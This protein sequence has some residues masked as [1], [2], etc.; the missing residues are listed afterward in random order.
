MGHCAHPKKGGLQ[1]IHQMK[2][3]IVQRYNRARKYLAVAE[4]RAKDFDT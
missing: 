2:P 3:E 4:A 1:P